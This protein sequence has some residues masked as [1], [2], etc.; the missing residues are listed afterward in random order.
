MTTSTDSCSLQ[1]SS[2]GFLPYQGKGVDTAA[3]AA[4][5]WAR[6][7]GRE[8]CMFSELNVFA[9][10]LFDGA[11]IL[12]NTFPRDVR[13]DRSVSLTTDGIQRTASEGG[14]ASRARFETLAKFNPD[15]ESEVEVALVLYC[16]DW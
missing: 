14:R 9:M 16:T 12:Y 15:M 3:P 1:R 2:L 8:W 4:S 7:I 13:A 6:H 5:K 11:G 10:V